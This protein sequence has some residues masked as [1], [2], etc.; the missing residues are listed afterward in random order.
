MRC[1]LLAVVVLAGCAGMTTLT[2]QQE[3][4]YRDFD[5]CQGRTATFHLER[6]NPDGSF[7]LSG[8]P[9]EQEHI[10]RCLRDKGYKIDGGY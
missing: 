6:V 9:H 2:P 1:V 4:V 3:R 7:T 10:A 8:R 5:A